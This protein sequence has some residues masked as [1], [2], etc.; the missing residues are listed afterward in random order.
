MPD[1]HI[2]IKGIC[3]KRKESSA[4]PILA[5]EQQN[6]LKC[7]A[8]SGLVDVSRPQ[9]NSFNRK[10]AEDPLLIVPNTPGAVYVSPFVERLRRR[11]EGKPYG[12]EEPGFPGVSMKKVQREAKRRLEEWRVAAKNI[13]PPPQSEGAAAAADVLAA[14]PRQK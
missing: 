9:Q 12:D 3:A 11:R 7:L 5:E 14:I 6:T 13:A 10:L 2:V 1:T 8:R 4:R